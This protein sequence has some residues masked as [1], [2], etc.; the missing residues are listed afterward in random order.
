MV[1]Y[2]VYR[3]INSKKMKSYGFQ[4]ARRDAYKKFFVHDIL[5]KNWYMVCDI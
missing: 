1:E 4:V 2:N 3:Y 5:L